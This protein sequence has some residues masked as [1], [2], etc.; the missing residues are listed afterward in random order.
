[1]TNQ[2]SACGTGCSSTAQF[3]PGCGIRL[4]STSSAGPTATR[5]SGLYGLG[6]AVGGATPLP[7]GTLLQGRY[8]IERVL[9]TGAFGR[10]YLAQDLQ[11]AAQPSV[12]IKELLD[13]QFSTPE[14]KHEA[15]MWFKREASTLLTLEHPGIPAIYTYWTAQ[16]S[17]D[18]FYLGNGVRP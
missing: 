1:M 9:G 7:P 12:A 18:P 3:C 4:G 13:A 15:V 6:I 5:Q 10:V 2:C 11:D 8:R 14:E 17:A 16:R